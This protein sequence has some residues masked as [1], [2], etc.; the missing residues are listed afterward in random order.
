MQNKTNRLTMVILG[1]VAVLVVFGSV[2]VMAEKPT[3]PKATLS[4]TLNINTATEKELVQLP[5]IGKKTAGNIVAYRQEYGQFK[6]VDDMLKVDGVG[7]K[8]LEKC[9]PYCST[10]GASTLQKLK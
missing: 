9:R 6:T 7:K 4:G 8:T 2:P 1:V 10:K 3:S 5:G